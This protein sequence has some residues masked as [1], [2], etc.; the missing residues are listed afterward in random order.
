[1]KIKKKYKVTFLLDPSNLWIENYLKNENFGL[2]NKFI[3]KITKNQNLVK[4]QDIVFPLSYTKILPNEFLKKN[5]LTLI[6]HASKLPK[7]RGA[8]PIQ[9]QVLEGKKK[10]FISLIK[11]EEKLDSGNIYCRNFFLLKGYELSDEI[12]KKQAETTFRVIKFFLNKFPKIRSKAQRGK[13]TFRKR[14]TPKDSKLNINK[15]IKSQFN[16]LRI[17]DN[18]SYPAYF[19]LKKKKYILKIFLEK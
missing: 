14:R 19:Y 12:R 16:L 4:N 11:A 6:A 1:M 2:K 15:S 5:K 10:F 3:F 13:P 8:A 18:K 17:C 9:Y 7:D